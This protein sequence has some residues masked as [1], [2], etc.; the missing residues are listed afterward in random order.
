MGE[1]PFR[2][3]LRV[4]SGSGVRR[5][6]GSENYGLDITAHVPAR[7][8]YG[9]VKSCSSGAAMGKREPARRRGREPERGVTR[10]RP[11]N[12]SVHV[13]LFLVI[14]HR[15]GMQGVHGALPCLRRIDGI[16]CGVGEGDIVPAFDDGLRQA[17]GAFLIQIV[18]HDDGVGIPKGRDVGADL[19]LVELGGQGSDVAAEDGGD[20]LG[21]AG[22][23]TQELQGDAAGRRR[24]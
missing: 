8:C 1:G 20:L 5:E 17:V 11:R 23:D 6:I 7:A 24:R 22:F 9:T 21:D 15:S 12:F 18:A 10:F 19:A 2:I 16:P 3:F 13:A 4:E 14:A